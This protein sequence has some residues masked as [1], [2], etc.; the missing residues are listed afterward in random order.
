MAQVAVHGKNQSLICYQ[1]QDE[2]LHDYEAICKA[3]DMIK[4]GKIIA[5]KGIGGYHL[6]VDA[7]NEAAVS[8][9]R[10]KKHR[11]GKPLAVMMLNTTEVE[12]YCEIS[13]SER[14]I[15]ESQ[16]API[17][18]LKR[19]KG[20]APLAYSLTK[21]LDTL[22]VML[23][24]TPVHKTL[25][26]K[27]GFPLVITSGNISDEPICICEEEAHSRLKNVADGFLHH[28]RPILNRIDDSVCF[29]AAA[30][31]RMVRR[32]RGF[33]NA[34]IMLDT[35]SKPVL[36][37]GAFYKNTF[38]LFD[39][40]KAY[41]SHHIGDLD[42]SLAYCYFKEE[43][44][45]YKRKYNINP[46]LVVRDLHPSYLSSLYADELGLPCL[47]V[48]HHH[49]HIASV[50]AEYGLREKVL[51]IAYDGTGLGSD[52]K[53]WGAE[54]LLADLKDFQRLGHLK[55]VPLPGGDLAVKHPFRTA[56]GFIYPNM[57]RFSKYIERLDGE[58]VKIIINQI[59]RKVNAPLASSM[60]RLFDAVASIINLRDTV[61]YEGQAALELESL[62]LPTNDCYGYRIEREGTGF[63]IDV[64]V[65]LEE[66]YTD[67]ING[68]P[69]GIISAKFHN[70]V[71][72]FT[73][74]LAKRIRDMNNVGKVVLS[75]GCF[76]NRYLLEGLNRELQGE[77]FA[78]YIPSK[79]PVND[80]GI[81][82]GQAAIA[83]TYF[84]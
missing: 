15:L 36:A 42:G 32:S 51:G 66:L 58:Q 53:I 17:V 44:Q 35:P 64:D 83:S 39:D 54:F 46:S 10:Q 69:Q 23:P 31:V 61:D 47:K 25:M 37:C 75:G 74:D 24:Y 59:E 26:E 41:V 14:Q 68:V 70:T 27:L 38:C 34:P 9:L 33:A 79:I 20:G 16:A 7:R 21:G 45:K 65:L 78:V 52:G 29:F 55:Y 11:Y 77:G 76:Q 49:A 63:F 1:A 13:I 19:R 72:N 4:Q 5:V 40:N 82:L 57:H 67:Y 6:A 71:I 22:G 12:K 84:S 3:V 8:R 56:L 73:L 30:G 48:Q 80:G 60:G 28:D 50:M 18:L 62:I 2:V 81:S 43:I